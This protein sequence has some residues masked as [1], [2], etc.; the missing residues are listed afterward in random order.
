MTHSYSGI[1]WSGSALAGLGLCVL[2]LICTI[3]PSSVPAQAMQRGVFVVSNDFGGVVGKRAAQIRRLNAAGRRV[4]IR[5]Q[6]CLSSC[7]MFLGAGDLCVHPDTRFGFHGPSNFGK[8]LKRQHFDHW[9]KVL[10]A[11]YPDAIADWF[12][13]TGRFKKHGYYTVMGSEIIRHGVPAC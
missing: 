1:T 10:A 8:P 9:S 7:T 6:F 3:Y 12:M 2:A 11:H 4:E 5:G 13:S